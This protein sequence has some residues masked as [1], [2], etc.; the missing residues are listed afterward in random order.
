[1]C[2]I[3]EYMSPEQVSQQGH[4]PAT[5]WWASGIL[6][7]ELMTGKTPFSGSS[8]TATLENIVA[9]TREGPVVV[10]DSKLSSA[11]TTLMNDLLDPDP[12]LRLGSGP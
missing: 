1:M 10:S 3:P 6:L 4:G 8:D 5:D 7:H 9:H 12:K 2:G 11:G